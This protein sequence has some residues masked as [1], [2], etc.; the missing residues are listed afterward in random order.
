MIYLPDLCRRYSL[1]I[2]QSPTSYSENVSE[3]RL[4]MFV[5]CY[6]TE[7]ANIS[8]RVSFPLQHDHNSHDP[9][10]DLLKPRMFAQ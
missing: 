4:P 8:T 6:V 10:H 9:Q 1:C 7:N 2:A 3:F 5:T